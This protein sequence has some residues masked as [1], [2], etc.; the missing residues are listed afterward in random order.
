M[1]LRIMSV[2][3]AFCNLNFKFFGRLHSNQFLLLPLE[4]KEVIFLTTLENN[5]SFG[6]SEGAEVSEFVD[7]STFSA[8]ARDCR[9]WSLRVS[10]AVA[11]GVSLLVLE[12]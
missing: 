7:S 2:F 10:L 8:K 1:L 11:G 9:V 5:E 4:K 3:E 12:E 6:C